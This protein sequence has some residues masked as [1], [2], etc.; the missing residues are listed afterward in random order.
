VA[1]ESATMAAGH[2]ADGRLEPVFGLDRAVV[3]KAHF[4]VYPARH[5]QR[6][7]VE[8]FV[9]WMHGEAARVVV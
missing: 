9:G 7:P 4:L 2:L 6:P 3:V 5:A 1:L 8:A